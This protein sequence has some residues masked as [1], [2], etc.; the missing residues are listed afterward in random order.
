M[1]RIMGRTQGGGCYGTI[2][3]QLS[4]PD[5]RDS[6][7]RL[8]WGRMILIPAR[9]ASKRFPKKALHP[10]GEVPMVVRVA[11]KAQLVDE[12][13]V[14][15]DA[16]EILSVCAE[17]HIRAIL[18]SAHHESGTDRIAEAARSLALPEEEIILNIQG[19]EPFLEI[20]TIKELKK[21]MRDALESAHPPFIASAYK[22]ISPQES[23]NP[24]LVKVVIDRH[25]NALYFS[26]L[27]IPYVR[28]PEEGVAAT[29]WGHLGMYAFTH[30]TL[31][32]FCRLE[33]STLEEREKLEQLRA[34]DHGYKILMCEVQ[35]QSIGIDTQEDLARA[36]ELFEGKF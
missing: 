4:S 29:Y 15:T 7:S 2:H 6:R 20:E 28:D 3:E 33:R 26:R 18:T 12:V 13:V 23:L 32:C 35:T 25:R 22:K 30:K 5:S 14:A 36:L 19:D 9:L 8:A 27:P 1:Q 10:I 17:H 31:Q 24:N 16:E 11:Q 34:L 21:C